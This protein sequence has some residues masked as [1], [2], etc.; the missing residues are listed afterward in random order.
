[1]STAS[2]INYLFTA[3]TIPPSRFYNNAKRYTLL[4]FKAQNNKKYHEAWKLSIPAKLNY[5]ADLIF[6][7]CMIPITCL[8]A[9]FGSI[10]AIYSWGD[11]TSF[12]QKNLQ[13]L[14]FHVNT[15]LADMIGIFITKAG[16]NLRQNNN[17]RDFIATTV[18]ISTVMLVFFAI[19]KADNFKIIYDP[20]SNSFKPAINWKL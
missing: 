8:K 18:L 13:V 10:Q 12:L 6:H 3:Q 11:E 4:S 9:F 15:A 7:I 16:I 5:L 14:H 20:S 1:M 17:V 2:L 19:K